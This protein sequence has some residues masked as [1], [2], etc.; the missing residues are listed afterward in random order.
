VELLRRGESGSG[1]TSS[2]G[3]PNPLRH[4]GTLV[5]TP[6]VWSSLW[7]GGI[8]K[9]WT[10]AACEKGLGGVS[11]LGTERLCSECLYLMGKTS[12]FEDVEAH[13]IHCLLF[14]NSPECLALILQMFR[15]KDMIQSL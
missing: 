7:L 14:R 4:W 12:P 15:E 3:W 10:S 1:C 13:L 2:E 6:A 8:S 11:L 9:L 5:R